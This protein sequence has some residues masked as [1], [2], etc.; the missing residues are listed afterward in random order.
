MHRVDD[1]GRLDAVVARKLPRQRL[2]VVVQVDVD[3][4]I[5][6]VAEAHIHRHQNRVVDARR[7]RYLGGRVQRLVV[8]IG[9]QR[10]LNARRVLGA[11]R[12]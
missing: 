10:A 12:P 3:G 2:R 5:F 7:R 11:I 6:V 9:R 4:Y 8:V 1:A